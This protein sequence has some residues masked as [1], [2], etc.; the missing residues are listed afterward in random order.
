MSIIDTRDIFFVNHDKTPLIH[1]Y[2]DDFKIHD[3]PITEKLTKF[4]ITNNNL[5]FDQHA[6]YIKCIGDSVKVSQMYTDKILYASDD[7]VCLDTVDRRS[8]N[9]FDSMSW[10]SDLYTVDTR[11]NITINRNPIAFADFVGKEDNYNKD[12]WHAGWT[13]WLEH[14]DIIAFDMIIPP[15]NYMYD[16][17]YITDI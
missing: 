8:S 4:T 12:R 10:R 11:E 6:I 7:N 9:I 16:Y 15:I 13:F 17:G 5:K 1:I 2:I 3:G 14:N